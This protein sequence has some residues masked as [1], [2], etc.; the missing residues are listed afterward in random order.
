MARPFYDRLREYYAAV[1][2]VLNGEAAAARI[3][4][5]SSDVGLTREAVYIKFLQQHAPKKCDI[6]LGGF[7]F[8]EDGS[9]SKQLDIIVTSDTTPRFY[10][11]F[12]ESSS[13]AFSPVEGSIA[14]ICVKSKID[15]NEL[16]DSLFNIASIPPM[17]DLSGRVNQFINI[18]DYED[19]PYK[20][21]YANDG[22]SAERLSEAIDIFYTENSN[23]PIHRRPNFIHVAGKYIALRGTDG[24]FSY[25]PDTDKTEDLNKEKFLFIKK[26]PDIQGLAW[27]ITEI[28][29]KS[30]ISTKIN[31]SYNWLINKINRLPNLA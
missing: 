26:D 3:F 27:I 24:I 15:K 10:M 28:Q 5:N 4:P 17:S 7:L 12:N 16:F 23:I 29:Q 20:V 11:N 19:W 8:H 25:N 13:K 9:E 1:A 2:S 14:V 31:Y 30:V 18:K 6:F 22:I 21:I